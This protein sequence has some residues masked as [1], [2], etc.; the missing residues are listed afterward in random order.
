MSNKTIIYPAHFEPAHSSVFI[1]NEIDID[2]SPEKVWYWLTNAGSWQD[3]YFNASKIK[4]LNQQNNHLLA[5]TKFTWK[6]FGANLK[7]K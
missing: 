3:W 4:I 5:G 6:T 7:V 1:Q 2:A